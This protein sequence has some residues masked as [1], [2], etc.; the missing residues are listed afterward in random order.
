MSTQIIY[1]KHT[2]VAW[3]IIAPNTAKTVRLWSWIRWRFARVKY[4]RFSRSSP[5]VSSTKNGGTVPYKAIVPLHKFISLHTAY[6]GEYLF[7]VPKNVWWVVMATISELPSLA[8]ATQIRAWLWDW[9]HSLVWKC[10][11]SS[12]RVI[13][14]RVD[15]WGEKTHLLYKNAKDRTDLRV[16]FKGLSLIGFTMICLQYHFIILISIDIH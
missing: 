4:D 12:H 2:Y 11:L 9:H 15:F 6:I 10:Q 1:T 3:H 16:P 7:S 5:R 13:H 8:M 14:F